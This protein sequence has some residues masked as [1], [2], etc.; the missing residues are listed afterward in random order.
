M[1]G[2]KATHPEADTRKRGPNGSLA[3]TDPDG[4]EGNQKGLINE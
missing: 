2:P 4:R 3:E 1:D